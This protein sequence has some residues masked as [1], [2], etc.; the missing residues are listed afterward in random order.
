[1]FRRG[2]ET[3]APYQALRWTASMYPLTA[4]EMSVATLARWVAK[5]GT[6]QG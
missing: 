5:G 4:V 1:M 2:L 3:R 6:N